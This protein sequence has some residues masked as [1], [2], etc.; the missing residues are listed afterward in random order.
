MVRNFTGAASRVNVKVA[1]SEAP[2]SRNDWWSKSML[3]EQRI[4]AFLL[5]ARSWTNE[6]ILSSRS[7]RTEYDESTLRVAN[8]APEIITTSSDKLSEGRVAILLCCIFV[9]FGAG[10]IVSSDRV[11]AFFGNAN[12]KKPSR[13]PKWILICT[14]ICCHTN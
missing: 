5:C 9:I 7:W 4:R 11:L 1:P 8:V 2:A 14:C 12:L 3:G 13:N 6:A 10:A